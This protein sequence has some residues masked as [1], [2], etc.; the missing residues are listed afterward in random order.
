MASYYNPSRRLSEWAA[1]LLAP[2]IKLEDEGVEV[3]GQKTHKSHVQGAQ[4]ARSNLSVGLWSGNVELKNVEIR[5]EALEKIINTDRDATFDSDSEYQIKWKVIEGSID[6]LKIQIP[7][8]SLLV[9]STHVS[10]NYYDPVDEGKE[11]SPGK[12]GGRDKE[13]LSCSGCTTVDVQGV[14]LVLTYE[15]VHRDP[16]LSALQDQNRGNTSKSQLEDDV[17][18]MDSAMRDKIR[19]EKNRV[20]QNSERRLLA[21]LVPFPPSEMEGLQSMI[22]SSIQ[23]G[24]QPARVGSSPLQSNDAPNNHATSSKDVNACTD[25]S[26]ATG[27]TSRSETYLSRV[28]NYLSSTIKSLL[29][30]VFDS[31]TLSVAQVQLSVMGHSHYNRNVESLLRS[32]GKERGKPH[33]NQQKRGQ[34][35]NLRQQ[36]FGDPRV[37]RSRH[38]SVHRRPSSMRSMRSVEKET[39]ND[40]EVERP[41]TW[42][43]E[44]Q[45]EFGLTWDRFD[46]RPG[47]FFAAQGAESS[48]FNDGSNRVPLGTIT[49]QIAVHQV[50]VFLRR[51]CSSMSDEE[52]VWEDN[53]RSDAEGEHTGKTLVWQEAAWTGAIG[54][55][56]ILGPTN[57]G[58]SCKVHRDMSGS[59]AGEADSSSPDDNGGV[60]SEVLSKSSTK[61]T[62]TSKR[63]GKRD[64][65]RKMIMGMPE[66]PLHPGF[67]HPPPL[68][69][70]TSQNVRTSGRPA[71][72]SVVTSTAPSTGSVACI[73][74]P[75]RTATPHVSISFEMGHVRSSV[76][77]YQIFLIDSFSTSI[78]RMKRGRPLTSVR[79]AQAYDRALL[80]RMAEEGQAILWEDKIGNRSVICREL[81]FLRSRSDQSVRTLPGVVTCWWKYAYFNVMAE[82]REQKALLGQCHHGSTRRGRGNRNIRG[83]ISS[84][85][86]SSR[87]KWDREKQSK[88][89]REYIDLYLLAGSDGGQQNAPTA[90]KIR[91]AKFR[92]QQLEDELCVERIL[93]LKNVG[94]AAS[95]HT[96]RG[97][98][99][100]GHAYEQRSPAETYYCFSPTLNRKEAAYSSWAH[101]INSTEKFSE[102]RRGVSPGHHSASNV[103]VG[104]VAT[105]KVSTKKRNGKGLLVQESTVTSGSARPISKGESPTDSSLSLSLNVYVSGFSLAL[106]EFSPVPARGTAAVE[107]KPAPANL[108]SMEHFADD[109]SA[110]TGYSGEDIPCPKQA[111]RD[112]FDPLYRFWPTTRHGFHC[113][114]I[115]LVHM[116]DMAFSVQTAKTDDLSP[117]HLGAEWRLGGLCL[118]GGSAPLQQNIFSLGNFGDSKAE[119]AFPLSAPPPNDDHVPSQ[120]IGIAGRYS[121]SKDLAI[122]VGPAEVAI[123]WAWLEKILHFV[124]DYKDVGPSRVTVPIV[125][126]DLI[127]NALSEKPDKGS[128]IGVSATLEFDKISLTIPVHLPAGDH[129]AKR[130]LLMTASTLLVKT[131][132]LH[133][134]FSQDQS[135]DALTGCSQTL[136]VLEGVDTVIVT[137]KS[138][139][140]DCT[141]TKL[142]RLLHLPISFQL[143]HSPKRGLREIKPQNQCQSCEANFSTINVLVSEFRLRILGEVMST[144]SRVLCGTGNAKEGQYLQPSMPALSET[145]LTEMVLSFQSLGVILMGDDENDCFELPSKESLL[146]RLEDIVTSYVTQASCLDLKYPDQN[147][148]RIITRFHMDRCCS[149]GFSKQEAKQ[150]MD[151]AR[152]HFEKEVKSMLL[153]ASSRDPAKVI[154]S[155][156]RKKPFLDMS[157]RVLS[158]KLDV[159]TA[160]ASKMTMLELGNNFPTFPV[161][162]SFG[163]KLDL[164][165]DAK[166]L[167]VSRSL[168]YWGSKVQITAESLGLQNDHVSLVNTK[169]ENKTPDQRALMISIRDDGS[170]QDIFFEMGNMEANFIPE[171]YVQVLNLCKSWNEADRGTGGRSQEVPPSS[172]AK[173]VTVNGTLSSFSVIL[174]DKFLPFMELQ[175]HDVTLG[176]SNAASHDAMVTSLRARELCVNC[177]FQ[178]NYPNVISTY[179]PTKSS[180]FDEH[181]AFSFQMSVPNNPTTSP[182]EIEIGLE[183]VR[184]LLLRQFLNEFLQYYQSSHYGIGLVLSHMMAASADEP[185]SPPSDLTVV[186]KN[187][188]IVLPRESKS[189]DMVAVEVEEISISRE[190]ATRSWSLE[191]HSFSDNASNGEKVAASWSSEMFFDCNDEDQFVA[192]RQQTTKQ[193]YAQRIPRFTVVLKHAHVFTA[194]NR[195]Q[196][197]SDK[198]PLP[199]LHANAQDTGRAEHNKPPFQMTGRLSNK[200]TEEDVKT[201]VWEQVTVDPLNLSIVVD[202]APMLRLLIEDVS[203]GESRGVS[204]DMR[205]SQFYLL[206]SIW[207]ENMQEL[208]VL[209]PYE[210]SYVEEHSANPDPPPDWPEYGSQEFVERLKFG[211]G[212]KVTFEM[213]LCFKN[214]TWRCSHDHPNYFTKT[215]LSSELLGD[216]KDKGCD[217]NYVDVELGNAVCSIAMDEDTLQRIGIGATSIKIYDG[218]SKKT[219]AQEIIVNDDGNSQSSYVDLSWGLDCGHH[220]L[221]NGLP[222]P[223][224]MTVFMTPDRYC[225]IN[226]GLDMAEASLFDL[227]RLGILSD[228]FGLYFTDSSYGHPAFEAAEMSQ[229]MSQSDETGGSSSDDD[230]EC[231]S[232]DFRLW[233]L[234]PHVIISSKATSEDICVMFEA[235]GL[236]YRYKSF[237][238][239]YSS[240][241]LVARSLGVSVLRGYLEPSKSRGLRQVSGSLDDGCGLKTLVDGLSFILRYDYNSSINY[242]RLALGPLRKEHFDRRSMDGIESSNFEAKP[243]LCMPPVVC[244]PFV[245]PSRTGHHDTSVYFNHECM[246]VAWGILSAFIGLPPAQE[247]ELTEKQAPDTIFSVTAHIEKVRL[248]VSD[249]MMGMHRPIVAICVPSLLLTASQLQSPVQHGHQPLNSS[250]VNQLPGMD[251][252]QEAKDMQVSLET[253]LYC[254][255]FKLGLTRNWEPCLEPF[256]SLIL[257]EK[258]SAGRGKGIT[259]NADCPLH[260][261]VTGAL[262]ET[263]DDAIK[264]FGLLSPGSTVPA[265]MLTKRH[266]GR[267]SKIMKSVPIDERSGN[268][269][270][271]HSSAQCLQEEERIAF[272]LKN[273]T[274]FEVRVHALSSLEQ[275]PGTGSGRQTTV[276]YLDHLH[277]M[278][279]TFPATETKIKN[280][281]SIEV[282]FEGDQNPASDERKQ[283]NTAT[284][285]EHLID[286]QVPGFLWARNISYDKPG[287]HFIGLIPR[288]LSVQTK[289]EKDWRLKN[290]LQILTELKSENG[291]RRLTITS[292]FEVVNKTNHPLSLAINPDPR[293]SPQDHFYGYLDPICESDQGSKPS[294]AEDVDFAIDKINPDEVHNLSHLLLESALRLNGNHLGSLWIRPH[295]ASSDDLEGISVGLNVLGPGKSTIGYPTRPVQLAKILHESSVIFKDANG[296]PN[297]ANRIASSGIGMEISCPIFDSRNCRSGRPFCYVLEVKRSPFRTSAQTPAI[298]PE[299]GGAADLLS[300]TRMMNLKNAKNIFAKNAPPEKVE[301]HAPIAY[302]LTVHPPLVIENLLPERG[303]FEIMDT[304]SK[305]VIWWGNLEAGERVAVHTVGLDAPLVLLVNL[306]FCRTAVGEGALIHHG[307]GGGIKAGWTNI[308]SA[309]KTSKD[310]VKRTLHTMTESKDNRGAKRVGMIKHVNMRK[311]DA[312][313]A[314]KTGQFGFN[315]ELERIDESSNRGGRRV[316]SYGLLEDIATEMNVTDSLGQRL[317][318]HIDNVLGSGGQR[319]IALYCPFWIVN[320]TEHPL[321]YKQEK[322]LSFVSGTV[323]SEEKDGSKPVDGSNRNDC[324]EANGRASETKL[325]S[326]NTIFS[327]RPGALSLLNSLND[328]DKPASVAALISENLPLSIVSKL[329]FM[330]NFQDDILPLGGP[331][332]LCI[333]LAGATKAGYTSAWSSGFGLESVGV[334]QI[335]GMHCKDGRGLEVMVSVSVAPGRLCNY[336]KIVRIC[337]RYIVVNQLNRSVR[338]WQDNSLIHPNLALEDSPKDNT[339]RKWIFCE[340]KGGDVTNQYDLLFGSLARIYR[341]GM[342]RHTTAHNDACYIATV[343]PSELVPFHLPDTRN[344]RLLRLELGPSWYLSPSFEADVT[345]E[346]VLAMSRVRDLRMLPHVS[347]RGAPVYTVTL[348][349][350]NMDWDGD[351]GVWFETDWDRKHTLIVKG[352]KEGSYASYFTDIIVGDELVMIDEVPVEQLTFDEAMKYLKVRLTAARQA[353][354]KR[355]SQSPVRPFQLIRA[356]SKK[357]TQETNSGELQSLEH[358]VT[359]TFLTLEERLRRLRRAAVSKN[360]VVPS[361]DGTRAQNNIDDLQEVDHAASLG[362]SSKQLFIELK[363]FHQSM[364]VFIREPDPNNPPHRI[365]NRSLHW[366]IYYRQKGCASHA[367]KSLS[368]GESADYTWAEPLKATKL[369]V[370]VGMTDDV[371]CRLQKQNILAAEG[372]SKTRRPLFQF[373]FIENEEQGHFGPTKSVKLVDIGSEVKLPCPACEN[374]L[375]C[376]VDTEG[377]TRVLKISDDVQL[378]NDETLVR[379]NIANIKREIADETSRR[380]NLDAMNKTLMSSLTSDIDMASV[381]RDGSIVRPDD[382]LPPAFHESIP[383]GL[384]RRANGRYLYFDLDD[385]EAFESELQEIADFDEGH[386]ITKCNQ[387]VV[388]VLEATGIRSTDL[389]G[390][391]NPYV[392]VGLI[393]GVKK[394]KTGFRKRQMRSTYYIAST[395]NP[396]WSHQSFVFDLPASASSDPRETRRFSIQC[397]VKSTEKFGKDKFLGQSY[398]HLRNLKDQRENVGWYPLMSEL[399]RSDTGKDPLDRVCGSIRLRVQYIHNYSGLLE[400]YL[401]CSDRRMKSLCKSRDGL[402]QQLKTLRDAAKQV[403]DQAESPSFA[404]A[405]PVLAAMYKK[406][407]GSF[408]PEYDRPSDAAK[409]VISA[410]QDKKTRAQNKFK[411]SIHAVRRMAASKVPGIDHKRSMM[412][413]SSWRG[414]L[415]SDDYSELSFDDISDESDEDSL[416]SGM[417][418]VEDTAS[419]GHCSLTRF[420]TG[421]N[422]ENKSSPT[423]LELPS[424]NNTSSPHLHAGS[425]TSNARLICLRWLSWEHYSTNNRALHSSPFHASWTISHAVVNGKA[426]TLHPPKTRLDVSLVDTHGVGRAVSLMANFLKLPPAAPIFNVKREHDHIRE[427]MESRASFSKAARRSLGSVL[428]PGGLL[429]ICPLTALNLPETFTGM[430]VK[431]RY[432]NVIRL[433]E[434]VESKV[435][436]VWTD[437]EAFHSAHNFRTSS[438]PNNKRNRRPFLMPRRGGDDG[439]GDFN[440]IGEIINPAFAWGRQR[441]NELDIE[442]EPFATSKSLRLTVI[443]ERLQSKVEIGVLEI[444]LGAALEACAQNMEDYKEDRNR[445]NP[446]GL[447]PA[448][449]RWFPLMSPSEAVPIEGD[450]GKSMRPKESEKLQ[451]SM[452]A[453]YFAPCI[454]LALLFRPNNVDSYDDDDDDDDGHNG[455]GEHSSSRSRTDQYSYVKLDRISAALIDSCRS[456]ELLSFSLCNA[457]LRYSV[458]TAKTRVALAVGNIQV[459][460]QCLRPNSKVPVILSPAPTS[461]PQPTVQ[462]MAWKDMLRSKG[463]IDSYD[464][465]YVAVQEMD[466]K[467][468]ESMLFDLWEFYVDVMKKREA[469]ATLR[470]QDTK[471]NLSTTA[472][473]ADQNDAVAKAT[474]FLVEERKSKRKKIYIKELILGFFQINLSYF[475][476]PKSGWGNNTEP[477][478]AAPYDAGRFDLF[479]SSLNPVQKAQGVDAY[480]LWSNN[481][482]SDA[483][484]GLLNQANISIV[485]AVFPSIS[486][487]PIKFQHKIYPHVYESEGEIFKSLKGWYSSDALRQIY[488]ILGSLDF[489]GNPTMVLTSFRTGLRDFFLQPSREFKH[490]TKNPSRVGVGVLKGTLS[491]LS[492]SAS[493]IFGFASNLGA[494]VGH[495]ATTLT[496]DSH[497]QRLRSEQKAA[498]QRHYDRWKKK[499]FGHVTLMVTRPVH[500]IVF[501]VMSA[502]TGLLTEPYRGARKDGLVGFAKGSAIGV[503]GVVVKPIVGVSD[504]FAHVTESIH[505][506]AKSVNLLEAKYKPIERYRHPYVFGLKQMLT[507]FNEVEASSAQLLL[508]H[509]LDKK[510]RGEEIIIASE[511]L[512]MGNG[513]EHYVIV[514]TMRVVSFRVKVIDGQGFVTVDLMWQVRFDKGTRIACSLG[515]RGHSGSILYVSRYSSQK[516]SPNV[517][518]ELSHTFISPEGSQQLDEQND[519]FLGED[520]GKIPDL[521][522]PKSYG[523]TAAYRL[524]T[525]W[526]FAPSEDDGQVARFAIEGSFLQRSQLCRIHNA[527]CCLSND[528]ESLII[529]GS[530]TVRSEGVTRFGPF[531]FEQDAPAALGRGMNLETLYS[532]LEQTEWKFDAMQQGNS[533]LCDLSRTSNQCRDPAWLIESRARGM[534]VPPPVSALPGKV[535]QILSELET[536]LLTPE[537][538]SSQTIHSHARTLKFDEISQGHS[539]HG[540]VHEDGSVGVDDGISLPKSVDAGCA[541]NL[542]EQDNFFNEGISPEVGS[543]DANALEEKLPIIDESSLIASHSESRALLPT[544]PSLSS[545]EGAPKETRQRSLALEERLQRVEDMLKCIVGSDSST[546]NTSRV[547]K[548]DA[549]TEMVDIESGSVNP[550]NDQAPAQQLLQEKG[551]ANVPFA[552]DNNGS[553]VTTDQ[554]VENCVEAT[555][556]EESIQP[557]P[558]KKLRGRIKKIFGEKQ[559]K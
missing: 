354:E 521:E 387:V 335:V 112:A 529:E 322:T 213:G 46:V 512:N 278:P 333:Q 75:V 74:G 431:L 297:E 539:Q 41:S 321:R 9:G 299:A 243:F 183:G 423:E 392:K 244:R 218:K 497:F 424:R 295:I 50:G 269:T 519:R 481:L 316:D 527:L 292:P 457:D 36:Q 61:G 13:D 356:K 450:M 256:K 37:H 307:G 351:L 3:D 184:I 139:R 287:K 34:Q 328:D 342:P 511:R 168:F 124:P 332:R 425:Y 104:R 473:E 154:R 216:D 317:T 261:N 39:S 143:Q 164:A 258:S 162:G 319:R 1:S 85:F 182:G 528:F 458:T 200:R 81:P 10:H 48:K 277:L 174:T 267:E 29:W 312:A 4:R 141:Q 546:V 533:L 395:L 38:Q 495:T 492:N 504:A 113:E 111:S 227:A 175:L 309:M 47:R 137:E 118:Q 367:W 468:E 83:F 409:V 191:G 430:F 17:L 484:E 380:E 52:S 517:D 513:I 232:I 535:T 224:Q 136:F 170:S 211:G 502:S 534:S 352:I 532:S 222:L 45:V 460:Q 559:G 262:I 294:I 489:V 507:P 419:P 219:F 448:Y 138:D 223:F 274:G 283:T 203:K 119:T 49:K 378:S 324:E 127:I 453:E 77:P 198:I 550:M 446:T 98:S 306:G 284:F 411:K 444:P 304:T 239:N 508:A 235:D 308:G 15:I 383:L 51:K 91:A 72:R 545:A 210:Q 506:M 447:R 557:N 166:S 467:M 412:S 63:R 142:I 334:T 105:S 552:A 443:G 320:T 488:K 179:Q 338:I 393:C 390:L 403:K 150:I 360:S 407:R 475:K 6:S 399:G 420:G 474:D 160:R 302:T 329:A 22:A 53:L 33:E 35:E 186:I 209:F 271:I 427:L 371:R 429:T 357:R 240:Q 541:E 220:T 270:F 542:Y 325:D 130:F 472:F 344:E 95:V 339:G 516:Q 432:D 18:P 345:G 151:T 422:Q 494:T 349:P 330:F 515:N 525:A 318:L 12:T 241:D 282:P 485:S 69:S 195:Q 428:N 470:H 159:L 78:T 401:L 140:A 435:A 60:S 146:H 477:N 101:P 350:T 486:E 54:D 402:R 503:I 266:S 234:K 87:L 405:A 288:S 496:L 25:A 362:G 11:G 238:Y 366:V 368:P 155:R 254:D 348:P 26:T 30:R 501:G 394:R 327:G 413:W 76:S 14:K 263:M 80:Q 253:T 493:G 117:N 129:E 398:V 363:F 102:S 303:R 265:P 518:L 255:Y 246:K 248:V 476:N 110:L 548:L 465:V 285:H 408:A 229:K 553:G 93:L 188:S 251:D 377:A 280:L 346:Y 451:D 438:F 436:P 483:D 301:A 206:M 509:P 530:H 116:A 68:P 8:K 523:P 456:L 32:N 94:R 374:Y 145:I 370:R 281:Q 459:D 272:S 353:V 336:T 291:G 66:A 44:G 275:L 225:L 331:P 406:K 369:S 434:T 176:K 298:K 59:F 454:K 108:G 185:P 264:T 315:T 441:S 82:V 555:S 126:E 221:V 196:F 544:F 326:L 445:V 231:L 201:R 421:D 109:L 121:G 120:S 293:S 461:N 558:R 388:E 58:A 156:R 433:S 88:I 134:D 157:P 79:A 416:G 289:I 296:D 540:G 245:T 114:P 163:S 28:E 268:L 90:T 249:P 364:F 204:F 452:F 391:S 180:R 21:G 414:S 178:A 172:P 40:G 230:N 158:D 86:D 482:Q 173:D 100:S 259:F 311:K 55:D 23:P 547:S 469:R 215:P 347:S 125:G 131:G 384:G 498:Q 463:D 437:E 208:P 300:P 193:G 418:L 531:I 31:L 396:T 84:A 449:V 410:E 462:F 226:L 242:T 233:M 471:S 520:G 313:A 386:F 106:C 359:L 171:A 27:M 385:P 323:S 537:N 556:T 228:Y 43:Q 19:E 491:L 279:L 132:S 337:P 464:I 64:K 20:L 133:D 187:S 199:E 549:T 379:R 122:S 389:G 99:V 400:Y 487:A 57:I 56:F 65:R 24:M 147:A 343:R 16:F 538:Y 543:I 442:V 382:D 247:H 212:A 514:T 500:D 92:L 499:G 404:R 148:L 260:L 144:A 192:S 197:S 522:T 115:T 505:D 415:D 314:R 551:V 376:Q 490:I 381:P 372:S 165:F 466:L 167:V 524:R 7:W 479:T 202:Y 96:P 236:H 205:M 67:I 207:Y 217:G 190:Q 103:H 478:E 310:R 169:E 252:F 161:S 455:D 42:A 257:Y 97:E 71:G 341:N 305:S 439:I 237:G 480:Q 440:D 123:D 526:P 5:P 189:V 62:D 536:G 181:F 128:P 397:V 2:Y 361:R 340:G 107:G 250:K 510:R 194:L 375:S 273:K 365:I 135:D 214:L 554:D 426:A 373:Q 177:A 149:M 286:V 73:D 152:L 417:L 355:D 290:A 89:R 358:F 153:P 276:I 70:P